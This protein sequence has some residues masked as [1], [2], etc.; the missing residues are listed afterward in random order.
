MAALGHDVRVEP[1][2]LKQYGDSWPVL[3]SWAL[4]LRAMESY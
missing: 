4:V 1:E 3:G 2:R